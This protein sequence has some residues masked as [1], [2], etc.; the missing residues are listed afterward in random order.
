[1]AAADGRQPRM[2]IKE[3]YP[4][5]H[6]EQRKHHVQETSMVSTTRKRREGS[7]RG[8]SASSSGY[9]ADIR[10]FSRNG[11]TQPKQPGGH[12]DNGSFPSS[13]RASSAVSGAA[14]GARG[15]RR[16]MPPI[17]GSRSSNQQ[18]D[19]PPSADDDRGV[20]AA[21]QMS[22]LLRPPS[23]QVAIRGELSLTSPRAWGDGD[24]ALT[25][26]TSLSPSLQPLPLF[27]TPVNTT[28]ATLLQ[29]LVFNARP[30][31][32]YA[33]RELYRQGSARPLTR[34]STA[35]TTLPGP[36]ALGT[37]V[38]TTRA[39]TP[40]LAT[41]RSVVGARSQSSSNLQ[42]YTIKPDDQVEEEGDDVDP[43]FFLTELEA[44]AQ[45][46]STAAVDRLRTLARHI[47][48]GA[49][50]L[51]GNPP[52]LV[53]AVEHFSAA[54]RM[55][56]P[57]QIDSEP[58]TPAD[59]AVAS[60][61][62]HHR[63]IAL[64]EVAISSSSTASKSAAVESTTL[65][66]A[67]QRRALELAQ[68]AEDS[69]LQARAVKALGLLL[70]DAH[71]FEP[72]LAH[73]QEALQLALE[74]KDRELEARV[75]AN[76]GNL[77][78]AQLQFGHALSCHQRDLDLCLSRAVDCR[79]G[80]ARAH[81]NLALVFAK[82]QRRGQQAKHEQEACKA[83]EE[84]GGAFLYDVTHHAGDSVGNLC[85]QPSTTLN[86][87]LVDLVAQ[88]LRDIER[89]NRPQDF[90]NVMDTPE[91]TPAATKT[92]GRRKERGLVVVLPTASREA[93]TSP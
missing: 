52:G 38:V 23:R 25:G 6:A 24:V 35:P 39:S 80:V 15:D 58:E 4:N 78:L 89:E 67:A 66:F 64:R 3:L 61:L 7:K 28:E 86:P 40:L 9:R 41:S 8:G 62:H 92:E 55:V 18:E 90:T 63:G 93:E 30:R 59:L 70:L 5:F 27:E 43:S 11:S 19:V 57:L 88:N 2:D 36:Q 46:A 48:R 74:A 56:E 22:P 91:L 26:L 17:S 47:A 54:L 21:V 44:A 14:R 45:A 71:A 12:Q 50:L 81:S 76:L 10:P 51:Y 16:A 13:R 37:D 75:Y 82:L 29:E 31:S 42:I 53:N 79:L 49:F 60:L 83:E 87:A 65:A 34:I 20:L 1:M 68:R 72:A 33:R 85:L 73:Q 32:R 77:A 84:G 69:R